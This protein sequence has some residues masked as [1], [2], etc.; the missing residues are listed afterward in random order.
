[1]HFRQHSKGENLAINNNFDNTENCAILSRVPSWWMWSIRI[2][3]LNSGHS[4]SPFA[5]E[6]ESIPPDHAHHLYH[7]RLSNTFPS[8]AYSRT[9]CARHYGHVVYILR[10]LVRIRHYSYIQCIFCMYVFARFATCSDR[11]IFICVSDF[12]AVSDVAS[13]WAAWLFLCRCPRIR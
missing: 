7:V 1:M 3:K 8:P 4:S 11:R 2:F 13:C 12:P 9:M 5:V 10:Y 6:G